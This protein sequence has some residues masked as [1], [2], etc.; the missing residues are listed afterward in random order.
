MMLYQPEQALGMLN[1][2]KI[3]TFHCDFG[4]VYLRG[5]LLFEGRTAL[6]FLKQSFIPELERWQSQ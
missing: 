2:I 1:I 4:L 6:P 3:L 5:C